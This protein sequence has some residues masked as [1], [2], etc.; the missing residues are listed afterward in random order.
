MIGNP[1]FVVV[2]SSSANGVGKS[3]LAA[4]LAVY[5]KALE[6]NLPVAFLSFDE[7]SDPAIM[8]PFRPTGREISSRIGAR[9][10]LC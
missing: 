8:F 5:L 6:E 10:D 9:G 7:Q 3:T 2:V 4:N 1:P